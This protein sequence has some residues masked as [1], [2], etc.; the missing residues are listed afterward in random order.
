MADKHRDVFGKGG[1]EESM[2]GT[3]LRTANGLECQRG[4]P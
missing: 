2:N 3:S 1:N 4:G